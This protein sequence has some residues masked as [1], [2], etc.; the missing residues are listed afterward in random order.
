[1]WNNGASYCVA[2]AEPQGPDREQDSQERSSVLGV[3]APPPRPDRPALT[4]ADLPSERS[5]EAG[6]PG[7]RPGTESSRSWQPIR[8]TS[9]R[10]GE[11]LQVTASSG[12]SVT[13]RAE[14]V[15]E[16]INNEVQ[17]S[18]EEEHDSKSRRSSAAQGA[19]S[20]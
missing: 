3:L 11:D 16:V 18:L 17:L 19:H 7:A 6:A 14:D 5:M 1:M 12:T 8:Q 20:R 9:S 13:H 4:F 2:S 10:P 15:L